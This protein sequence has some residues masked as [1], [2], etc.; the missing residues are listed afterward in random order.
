VP[1]QLGINRKFFYGVSCCLF[2]FVTHGLT[3]SDGVIADLLVYRAAELTTE[4]LCVFPPEM[5]SLVRRSSRE[6]T[7]HRE[8]KPPS[9][10]LNVSRSSERGRHFHYHREPY[11]NLGDHE[12]S[13]KNQDA[14]TD[15]IELGVQRKTGCGVEITPG[16]AITD[17]TPRQGTV[18]VG[19]GVT[20]NSEGLEPH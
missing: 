7:G 5:N 9:A 17:E 10:Y 14:G 15:F 8:S 16:L 2:I 13:T 12:E 6:G 1:I 3:L 20:V 19:R 4:N 11:Q 18:L